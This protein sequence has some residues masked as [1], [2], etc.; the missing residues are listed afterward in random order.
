VTAPL[1]LAVEDFTAGNVVRWFTTAS[2]WRGANGIPH[3]LFEH[4]QMSI[5]A[6]LLAAVIALPIGLFLGHLH[7]GGFIAINL[8]NIGR[9]IPSF[10]ILVIGAVMFGVGAQPA[11][12]ALVALAIPPM[13][14]NAYVGVR[15][16]DP[17]AIEAARGM[18][19]TGAQ[20]LGKVE[21]P[22][23]LPLVM[24]GIR[25]STVQVVATA[26]LAAVIGW[27]GLGRFIVDGLAQRDFVQVFAGALIVAALSVITELVFALLQRLVVSRGLQTRSYSGQTGPVVGAV[28]AL[29]PAQG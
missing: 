24:A 19:M 15:E 2:H 11:F 27:G 22:M 20:L 10:A 4:L 13:V 29:E 16:V 25:T 1:L 23:A 12:V 3:R 14:T 6:S 28:G 18:G 7:R 21:V 26:T 8:A 9:A 5:G 17:E